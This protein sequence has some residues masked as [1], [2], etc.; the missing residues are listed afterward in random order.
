M[1]RQRSQSWDAS[2]HD[3][4]ELLRQQSERPLNDQNSIFTMIVNHNIIKDISIIETYK[5]VD[6][7]SI[8]KKHYV[9]YVI[10]IK[11]DYFDYTVAKRYSEFEK[12][13]EQV[14]PILHKLPKFPEKKLIKSNSKKNIAERKEMLEEILKYIQKNLNNQMH[15]FLNFLNIQQQFLKG[16]FGQNVR[17]HELSR[18][19]LG[20]IDLK[21][22]AKLTASNE[23]EK[24]TFHYIVKLNDRIDEKSKIFSKMEQ[25]FFGKTQYLNSQLL[26]FLLL[27]DDSKYKGIIE[28]LR[29]PSKDSQS[30]ISCVSGF[31][32][33][34][35]MLEYDYNPN[36]DFFLK[37]FSEL[38]I[39]QFK[40]IGL[41]FHICSR[42]KQLC[43]QHTLLL[44]YKYVKGN[45]LKPEFI[46]F[47]LEDQDA[48][49]EFN[50]FSEIYQQKKEEPFQ[51]VIDNNYYDDNQRDNLPTKSSSK[52]QQC[53]L[54]QDPTLELLQEIIKSTSISWKLVQE[55]EN[56]SF[57]H[58]Q[59]QIVKTIHPLKCNLEK[60]IEIVTTA[61]QK[62]VATMIS[63]QQLKKI[64]DN[65]YVIAETYLWQDKQLFKK[66]VFFS[67]ETII[68]NENKFEILMQP[69]FEIQEYEQF[70]KY[71]EIS[72]KLQITYGVYENGITTVTIIQ[73][74]FDKVQ[75]LQYTPLLLK[76]VNY[77][78]KSIQQLQI[79]QSE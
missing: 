19:E 67:Q 60:A 4:S 14:S 2:N 71:D 3:S 51:L 32:F 30:H 54:E 11:T 28:L 35:K 56:H 39:K 59:G 57:Q 6:K 79:L 33:L 66:V 5:E 65:K 75:Q 48:L 25:Y 62:W 55:F 29:N 50:S 26:K 64:N 24:M 74:L 53:L 10:K 52:E 38:S 47:L 76:E 27:G 40:K 20:L 34:R 42:N 8:H 1:K 36:A 58:I 22:T 78:E 9:N 21:E 46:N 13:Y 12:L 41:S 31:Q 37:I 17:I 77:F 45:D 16:G 18:D 70:Q 15:S 73:N 69:E 49:Q 44:I 68:I 72:Q 7:I 63:R 23:L 43:K 61:K